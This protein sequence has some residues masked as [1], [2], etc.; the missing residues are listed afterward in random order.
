MTYNAT[1]GT[2]WRH[3]YADATLFKP[4][5]SPY[6]AGWGYMV[7]SAAYIDGYMKGEG[8]REK[9]GIT[10]LYNNEKGIL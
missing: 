10:P 3:G 6:P 9:A 1:Y 7:K 5:K 4:C 2:A 8:A